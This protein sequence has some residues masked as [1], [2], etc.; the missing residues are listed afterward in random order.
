[1]SA[2]LRDGSR[3]RERFDR[4]VKAVARLKHPNIVPVFEAGEHQG[5]A[6]FT[7]EHVE[8][9]SLAQVIARLK[10]R[11]GSP[12]KL[13][14]ADVA[15]AIDDAAAPAASDAWRGGYVETACRIVRD[16]A[17]ALE[18][19]HRSGV[20]HRDLKPSNVLIQIDGGALLFDFG[21]ARLVDDPGLTSTGGTPRPSRGPSKGCAC[22]ATSESSISANSSATPSRRSSPSCAPRAATRRSSPCAA[23]T[24]TWAGN[25]SPG[26]IPRP[27]SHLPSGRHAT[28]ARQAHPASRSSGRNPSSG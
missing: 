15:R 9:R 5:V 27:R 10:E 20:V 6:F 13:R 17:L 25:S 1:M 7:M 12:A 18:H 23:W 8:G 26:P 24:R 21:L 22:C 19:A 4:E 14:A 16:L 3:G 28:P 11:H 2:P